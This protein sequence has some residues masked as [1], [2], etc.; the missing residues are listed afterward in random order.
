MATRATQDHVRPD[1]PESS[2][3][4]QEAGRPAPVEPLRSIARPLPQPL[5]LSQRGRT[6]PISVG[7]AVLPKTVGL[8]RKILIG[9]LT[10]WLVLTG[11]LTY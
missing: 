9:D 3:L 8:F 10:L 1:G 5:L 7:R 11:V 2:R 4:G 6:A